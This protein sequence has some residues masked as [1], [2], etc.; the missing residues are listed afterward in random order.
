MRHRMTHALSAAMYLGVSAIAMAAQ[1]DSR[2]PFVIEGR[3]F[4]SQE[5]FIA[6]G[7]RC[8]T[9]HVDAIRAAEIDADIAARL[10][11]RGPAKGP[12]PPPPPPA[13][14]GG[15]ID[16]YVHVILARDGTGGV[17]AE[18]IEDQ[19]DVLNAAYSDS[20]WQFRLVHTDWTVNQAWHTM[21]SGTTAEAEAKAELRQGEADD[22]NIYIAKIGD[23]LLGWATFP[24]NYESHPLMDGVVI[25]NASL[26]G[27]SAA[28][29]NLGDTA[30]HEVGHWMGLY[31]TFQGGCTKSNDLVADTPAERSPAFGCP[32]GRDTCRSKNHPGLDPIEN[33]MDYTDDFCMDRF[34]AGQ[35]VRMD[36]A[37]SAYRD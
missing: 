26:P 3:S 37:F 28:P 22:L 32:V 29:Y 12:S 8:G 35:D 9:P 34:T 16:V 20:D 11:G 30:T 33:F 18:Q 27:G 25:L 6:A 4:V 15:T 36:S 21:T 1:P 5:A 19:I 13:V 7:L 10:G 2:R 31:H 24:W 14:T 17:S 23:G